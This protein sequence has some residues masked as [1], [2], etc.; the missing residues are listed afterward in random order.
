MTFSIVARCEHTGELGVGAV[1]GMPGVGKLLTWAR[2]G[3]G[4]V[5]TQ[6]WINPY[7][8]IDALA[9]LGTGHTA[10]KALHAVTALDDD[11]ELRQAGVVD[12]GG[13][14]AAW[15]GAALE[16]VTGDVQGDG[17][18]VQGN[19][20]EAAA[21]LEACA[22]AFESSAG[23]ELVDRLIAALEAGQ[24]AGGDRRG[25]H[26]ATVYV[27]A[28]EHYPLWDIRIDDAD[29]PLIELRRMQQRFAEQLIPHIRALPTRRNLK[30]SLAPGERTGLV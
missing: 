5:A 11:R 22:E 20:L 19:L 17:W 6:G 15:T 10:A 24:R 26:S 21:V 7:L 30:G 12:A 9:M 23:Q 2:P 16:P 3:V 8:A 27:V 14:A 18:T 13:R 29:D 28:T 1:T 25:A 4:A